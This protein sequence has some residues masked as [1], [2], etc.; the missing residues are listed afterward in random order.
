MTYKML[1]KKT[2]KEIVTKSIKDV[3]AVHT[4]ISETYGIVNVYVTYGAHVVHQVN[5]TIVEDK[6]NTVDGKI[7]MYEVKDLETNLEKAFQK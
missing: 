5:L 7:R 4:T 3:K 2:Y 1:D 6:V